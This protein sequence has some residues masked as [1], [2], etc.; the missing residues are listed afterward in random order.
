MK[1]LLF[2]T[3]EKVKKAIDSFNRLLVNEDWKLIVDI[4][5]ENIEIARMQLEVGEVGD[6][7][8]TVRILRAGIKTWKEVRD[9]PQ[10]MLKLLQKEHIDA[11]NSDPYITTQDLPG[12]EA[13]RS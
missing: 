3:P 11:P 4:L 9:T 2:D 1:D 12:N 5:N 8:E 6:T 13:E 7:I 10:H